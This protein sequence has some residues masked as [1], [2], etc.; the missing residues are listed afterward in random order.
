ME[1]KPRVSENGRVYFKYNPGAVYE[2]R[3]EI[4]APFCYKI[5]SCEFEDGTEYYRIESDGQ[6]LPTRFT[7]CQLEFV[8]GRLPCELLEPGE[9]VE[10]PLLVQEVEKYF[11]A[12]RKELNRLNAAA[13]NRLKDTDYFKNK[14]AIEALTER[15]RLAKSSGKSDLIDKYTAKLAELDGEQFVILKEKSIDLKVL[16]KAADC[17]LC[18]DNGIKD[19][20]ICTCALALAEKIKLY[21]IELRLAE[22]ATV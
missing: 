7:L 18:G 2:L 22:N 11:G 14:S 8:L 12:K 10:L 19:G 13:N 17:Q 4:H 3:P 15:L 20:R 9:P 6:E 21:N 16:T 1:Y 5:L